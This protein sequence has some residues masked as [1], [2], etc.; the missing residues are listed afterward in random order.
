MKTI[1]ML[2][3]IR[4]TDDQYSELLNSNSSLTVREIVRDTLAD[5]ESDAIT[6]SDPLI[7]IPLPPNK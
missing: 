3:T 5:G 2:S 7:L 1:H 6:F 4:L